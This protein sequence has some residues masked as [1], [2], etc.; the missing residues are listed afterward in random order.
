MLLDE[1]PLDICNEHLNGQ[2]VF[3]LFS[4]SDFE[5]IIVL[6]LFRLL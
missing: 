2:L 3:I 6:G 1:I 4:F 5:E